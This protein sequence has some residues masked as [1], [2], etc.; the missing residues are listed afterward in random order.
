MY[1]LFINKPSCRLHPR[2]Q[3]PRH[4]PCFSVERYAPLGYL[5]FVF[6][7]GTAFVYA[8]AEL[9]EQ[10]ISVLQGARSVVGNFVTLVA[11]TLVWAVVTVVG[12]V[13]FVLP[14]IYL[15]TRLVLAFPSCVIDETGLVESFETS[16]ERTRGAV[17]TL[18]GILL[19]LLLPAI[20][21]ATILIQRE[22]P[23]LPVSDEC[24]D[25][26]SEPRN[27]QGGSESRKLCATNHSVSP[28]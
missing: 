4:S 9:R 3:A 17:P 6:A 18:L 23:A 5:L 14:G 26:Q 8:D 24:S 16:W 11:V 7:A 15:G 22:N 13:F 2:G 12:L 10:N 27:E 20:A 28:C 25:T 1:D 19:T 21:T